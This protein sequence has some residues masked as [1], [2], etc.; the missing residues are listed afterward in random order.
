MLKTQADLAWDMGVSLETVKGWAKQGMPG[1]SGR[2]VVR[3]VTTWL[4]QEGPWRQHMRLAVDPDEELLAGGS[5]SPALERLRAAKAAIA[6]LDLE[7][8]RGSLVSRE[9]ARTILGRWAAILRR[10]GERLGKRYGPEAANAVNDALGECDHVVHHELG[11]G[12]ATG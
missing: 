9:K 7:K 11:D 2:Y 12:N 5:D 3:D 8:L 6:E 4:R 1:R 10:M